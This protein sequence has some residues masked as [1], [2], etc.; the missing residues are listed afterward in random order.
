MRSPFASHDRGVDCPRVVVG[1]A[2]QMTS[3]LPV[4]RSSGRNYELIPEINDMVQISE[5]LMEG[6]T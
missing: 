4:R 1:C 3:V 6:S 5:D 2:A